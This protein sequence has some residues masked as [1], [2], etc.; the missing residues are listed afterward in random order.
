MRK[1]VQRCLWGNQY[2]RFWTPLRDKTLTILRKHGYTYAECGEVLGT[3]AVACKHRVC[4]VRLD[5]IEKDMLTGL[6]K[7]ELEGLVNKFSG[8]GITDVQ[9][10]DK[11]GISRSWVTKVRKRLN[12]PSGCGWGGQKGSNGPRYKGT[13]PKV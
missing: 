12:I 5:C 2:Q 13:N 6:S 7:E 8:E 10:A 4:R 11:I 1:S 9:I 3:S